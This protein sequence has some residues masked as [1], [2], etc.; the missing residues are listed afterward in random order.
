MIDL[1]VGAGPCFALLRP[2]HLTSIEAPLSAVR[3]VLTGVPD[4]QPIDRPTAECATLA[5]RDLKPGEKLGKIGER[6]YRAW[7][8]TAEALRAVPL[9]LEEGA[10]VLRPIAKGEM[11]T[12]DN[13]A[14]DETLTVTRLRRAQ[15]VPDAAAMA[16]A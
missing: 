11:L 1:K 3:A 4:M 10:T 12:A 2:C 13:C 9:G 16:A 6:D 8:V 7:A 15:D 5:K 14:P